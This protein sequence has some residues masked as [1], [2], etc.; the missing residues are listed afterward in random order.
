MG[1]PS[2]IPPGSSSSFSLANPTVFLDLSY[3]FSLVHPT[4]LPGSFYPSLWFIL[5]LLYG[6]SYSFSLVHPTLSPKFIL[7][8]I[9][10][11]PTPSPRFI[12]LLLS[13]SSYSFSV[14]NPTLLH[15]SS[16]PSSWFILLLLPSLVYP[17]PSLLL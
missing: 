10:V 9:L 3:S 12:L 4:L 16:Y 2:L 8:F 6:S 11:L 7:P 13:D 1:Y 5:L 17:T 14:V 15:G